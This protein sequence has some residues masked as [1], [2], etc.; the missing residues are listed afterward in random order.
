MKKLNILLPLA[1]IFNLVLNFGEALMPLPSES[2]PSAIQFNNSNQDFAVLYWKHSSETITFELIT[3]RT[4]W[5]LFGLHN[6]HAFSDVCLAWLNPSNDGYGHFSDRRLVVADEGNFMPVDRVQNWLHVAVFNYDEYTVYKFLRRIK[7]V[8]SASDL[9]QEDLNIESG[10]NLLILSRP[11]STNSF[12]IQNTIKSVVLLNENLGP[13]Q[14][15]NKV[16]PKQE[17]TSTPTTHY[18]NYIDLIE[19]G[20]YRLYWN[21][22]GED[23]VGEI[24]CRTQ[25]WL[26]FGLSPS[27][28]RTDG[29]DLIVGWVRNGA[30]NFTDRFVSGG[31]LNVDPVQ[32]WF[33]LF[34]AEIG[35]YTIL[36]FTRKIVLCNSDDQTI[37]AW[38]FYAQF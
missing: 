34:S 10:V 11:S 19:N 38:N 29:S 12:E 7:V 5:I 13:F 27:G 22:T 31:S 23:F 8:C 35:G 28:S 14:C 18:S 3:R 2:Y 25:G 36:K 24:H 30:V 37:E 32:N 26:A 17:F 15:R 6:P 9:V 16:Q 33:L 20:T 21:F 1:C 4:G